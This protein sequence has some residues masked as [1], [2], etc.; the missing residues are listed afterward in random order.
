MVLSRAGGGRVMAEMI[1]ADLAE[2]AP[3][4]PDG[5]VN[6]LHYGAWLAKEM[7]RSGD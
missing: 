7:R 4:N 2:G 6:L 1:R 5:T 3:Q